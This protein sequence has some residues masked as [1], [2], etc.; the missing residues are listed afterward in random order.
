MKLT[1]YGHS[2]FLVETEL[3]SVVFDPYAPGSVPGL[4]LP[5]LAADAVICSHGHADH[6]YSAGV[7]LS[8]REPGFSVTHLECFHDDRRG[9]LRGKNTATLI[10]AEGIRLLHLGDLGHE[11]SPEQLAALGRVDVLLLPVGGYF[12]IDAAAAD[13][14]ARALGAH[15]VIPMHYRGEGFGYDVIAPVEDYLKLADNVRRFDTNTLTLSQPL[16]AM[17]AVLSL[18]DCVKTCS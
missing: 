1:W 5:P 17:T 6:A 10:E 9:A 16:D 18:P 15:V 3:G 8:G 2:C 11:L 13:K 12:T 4:S 14:T 7:A